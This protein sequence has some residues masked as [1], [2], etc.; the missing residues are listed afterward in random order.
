MITLQEI[1]KTA[2]LAKIEITEQEAQLYTTQLSAVLDW[3]AKLQE[4]K[5]EPANQTD[6][7]CTYQRPDIPVNFEDAPALSA[8]F[9]DKK[10]NFLKVKKVL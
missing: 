3:V 4:I 6:P 7:A 9:N 1:K 10:D 2:K 8:A 5:T